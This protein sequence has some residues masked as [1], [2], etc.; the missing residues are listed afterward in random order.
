MRFNFC[1]PGL[2]QGSGPGIN[3]FYGIFFALKNL[4]NVCED[5]YV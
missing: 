2:G 5:Y 3:M 1:M 4:I